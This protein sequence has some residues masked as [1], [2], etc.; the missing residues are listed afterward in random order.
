MAITVDW[1]NRIINV[2]RADMTLV[3]SVPTEIRELD[4]DFFRLTLKALE[5]GPEGMSYPDIHNHTA[6]VVISGASLA[7]VVEI[8]NGYTITFEDGQYR[9]Q[10]V[11][12]N[13]NIG[14]VANVNQ[15]GISTA[16]SAG[17]VQVTSGSGLSAEQA[18]RL[19]DIE[20]ALAAQGI[21]IDD[22]DADVAAQGTR[23]DALDAA[24]ADVDTDVAAVDTAVAVNLTALDNIGSSVGAIDPPTA[25]EIADAVWNETL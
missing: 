15:V 20:N 6:P 14:D 4:A 21:K 18:Q 23:F 17:V 2:P 9:V 1:E 12:G 24:V 13:T 3:Q 16:N 8:I 19:I 22:I 10:V 5:S 25:S 7:R 11:G